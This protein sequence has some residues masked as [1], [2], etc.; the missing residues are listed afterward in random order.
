[1]FVRVNTARDAFQLILGQKRRTHIGVAIY[2]WCLLSSR[3]VTV[4][5]LP[6]CLGLYKFPFLLQ[7]LENCFFRTYQKPPV[8]SIVSLFL[9]TYDVPPPFQPQ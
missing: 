5:Q 1:M 8:D 2:C 7:L 3:F 6:G 4:F 9:K